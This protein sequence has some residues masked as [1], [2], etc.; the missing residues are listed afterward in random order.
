MW[1]SRNHSDESVASS[2]LVPIRI[3]IIIIICFI[4]ISKVQQ[5]FSRATQQISTWMIRKKACWMQDKIWMITHLIIRTW[6]ALIILLIKQTRRISLM[7][8]C[9][10]SKHLRF[11]SRY[12]KLSKTCLIWIL[13]LISSIIKS[14][15]TPTI[16]I[17][18]LQ[19]IM[20]LSWGKV[21]TEELVW[22]KMIIS[23]VWK[24]PIK[25]VLPYLSMH[26]LRLPKLEAVH[27]KRVSSLLNTT[28]T[29]N[30]KWWVKKVDLVAT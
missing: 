16:I 7:N 8:I 25:C 15:K 20:P 17:Y 22:Y 19:I 28:K 11:G 18:N 2:M 10:N 4:T 30:N 24:V 9:S 23:M 6:M 26:S 27:P 21:Y 29:S 13:I 14:L 3:K 12:S 5:I 1:A